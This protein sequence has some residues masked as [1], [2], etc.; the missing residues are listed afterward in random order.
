MT[1]RPVQLLAGRGA[2]NIFDAHHH[3]PAGPELKRAG[4]RR[5]T[6]S[7]LEAECWVSM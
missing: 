7:G 3:P 6:R 1:V 2:K 5:A 4:N